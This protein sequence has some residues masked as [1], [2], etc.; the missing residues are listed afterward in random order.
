[1]PHPARFV[2]ALG[3]ILS[4]LLPRAPAAETAD[5]V[6]FEGILDATQAARALTRFDISLE[7]PVSP[8]MADDAA[9]YL[10]EVL[11][12]RGYADAEVGYSFD[13]RTVTFRA[14]GGRTYRIGD[15]RFAG[16]DAASPERRQAVFANALRRATLT[17]I[18]PLHFVE[19]AVNQAADQLATTY[20]D[21]G[22][23]EAKV[24]W[25]P[26]FLGQTVDLDVSIDQ[27]PLHR[28]QS[29]TLRGEGI[30]EEAAREV[31]KPVGETFTPGRAA[32]LRSGLLD[33]LRNAGFA[34]AVVVESVAMQ[35]SGAVDVVLHVTPGPRYRLGSLRIKGT[36]RTHHAAV[37]GRMGLAAGE[38]F[39]AGAVNAAIRRLWMT[40]AFQDIET[41]TEKA[42]G[43]T[44]DLVVKLREGRARQI[45]ATVGYG[46]WEQAFATVT[47]SDRN[48]LGTLNRF[49][50]TATASTKSLGLVAGV[51]NPWLFRME[52]T[53]TAKAFFLR[54]ETP[55]Y[56]S[57]FYGGVAE[58]VRRPNP[59]NT[60]GW[61]AGY[62][63]L[64]ST[65]TTIFAENALEGTD[66]DY[67]LGEISFGQTL[68]RRNDPLTPMAGC[69]LGWDAA[70]ASRA[71]LGDVSFGRLETRATA[72]IPLRR[73]LPERPFVP[74]VALNSRTGIM[75]PYA[76]TR[77]V[78][79]QERFFLGGPDTVRGFLLD[80]M[81]P[82]DK[83]GNPSGGLLSLLANA[84][85]QVPVRGPLYAV[86][87]V[88]AGNLA[89]TVSAFQWADTRVAAGL[90][91]RIYT[92][93]GAIRLDYGYNL[94]RKNGD[95]V[96]AWQFGFGFTF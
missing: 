12:G 66:A 1:M 92:P 47:Y 32:V 15:V 34:D 80:G 33:S 68:D 35:I 58:I 24:T 14:D 64:A 38:P 31:M 39:D 85:I 30:P 27:G 93:L 60:T 25:E 62:T 42:G 48:V 79:V 56:R 96:G 28:L 43:D 86:A 22:H 90:G 67:H 91:A 50:V 3:L 74:F 71:L 72:Y 7:P 95:P 21:L 9:F 81:A 94:I 55:A 84:E 49:F 18:G 78:P 6:I 46:Q 88:D 37:S 29:V 11:R 70:L 44:L 19:R 89:P 36:G 83:F 4:G 13:G 65:N 63:W 82:R 23:L 75:A 20:R 76:D 26:V 40:G 54:R 51:G 17:P 41:S 16:G 77:E 8:P 45:S 87:F 73:I 52:A 69:L 10:G 2:T 53:G 57:T 61:R 5:R 59:R